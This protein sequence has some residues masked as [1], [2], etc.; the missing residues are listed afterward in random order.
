KPGEPALRVR[1]NE[2]DGPEKL[3]EICQGDIVRLP[4]MINKPAKLTIKQLKHMEAFPG[5]KNLRVVG[6]EL[7]VVIDLRGRPL[8][9]PSDP[10]TRR[11][12]YLHWQNTLK[13]CLG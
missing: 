8:S 5:S 6:G 1:L 7:G 11:K 4:L 9:I 12:T 10:E 13:E 3:Y 2:E